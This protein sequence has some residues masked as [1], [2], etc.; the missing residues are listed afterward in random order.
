MVNWDYVRNLMSGQVVQNLN[1]QNDKVVQKLNGVVQKLNGGSSETEL[2]NNIYNNNNNNILPQ[3]NKISAAQI[4]KLKK[5]DD[6]SH[7]NNNNDK[8]Y[9]NKPEYDNN[10]ISPLDTKQ[11]KKKNA[12]VVEKSEKSGGRERKMLF[13]NSIYYK[14]S[15]ALMGKIMEMDKKRREL[16][17]RAY[18]PYYVEL[19]ANWSASADKKRTNNGWYRTILNFI[20]KDKERG[21]LMTKSRYVTKIKRETERMD[22]SNSRLLD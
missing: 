18:L 19:V 8:G 16:Y 20:L 9:L 3:P 22:N 2:N 14:D 12:P 21:N 10:N 17:A 13:E 15:R 11:L 5:D 7:Y 4:E 1:R 6:D